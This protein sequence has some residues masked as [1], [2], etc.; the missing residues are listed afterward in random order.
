MHEQIDA[1][2]PPI[3]FG[4]NIDVSKNIFSFTDPA[5]AFNLIAVNKQFYRI[6]KGILDSIH[7]DPEALL[8]YNPIKFLEAASDEDVQSLIDEHQKLRFR[9]LIVKINQD[10]NLE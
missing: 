5:D 4:L 10:D 1:P 8:A 9:F 2:Q 7:S 6:I 3:N